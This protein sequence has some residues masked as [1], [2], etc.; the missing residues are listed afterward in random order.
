MPRK[1]GPPVNA[2]R[3]ANPKQ[4]RVDVPEGWP[5]PEGRFAR[6]AAALNF[7]TPSEYIRRRLDEALKADG[8]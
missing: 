2:P 4:L 1:K 7:P 6:A 8:F 3:G 5:G